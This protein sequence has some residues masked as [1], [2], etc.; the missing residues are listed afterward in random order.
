[1]LF[2]AKHSEYY[3]IQEIDSEENDYP[4]DNGIE[5]NSTLKDGWRIIEQLKDFAAEKCPSL[6]DELLNFEI[7]FCCYLRNKIGAHT[8]IGYF[9][10]TLQDMLSLW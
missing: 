5:K 4:S 1:M 2:S 8:K 3:E 10:Q 9:F 7:G 6:L